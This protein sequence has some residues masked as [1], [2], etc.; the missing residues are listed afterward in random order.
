M[1]LAKAMNLGLNLDTLQRNAEEIVD[2]EYQLAIQFKY[3]IL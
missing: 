3:G 2:F 1:A